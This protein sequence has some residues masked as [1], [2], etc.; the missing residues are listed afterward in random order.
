VVD[1]ARLQIPLCGLRDGDSFAFQILSQAVVQFG[2]TAQLE[3]GHRL[4]VLLD[5]RRVA[6]VAR[7]VSGRHV[8]GELRSRLLISA[9]K[10]FHISYLA[11]HARRR[12]PYQRGALRQVI[13]RS[14]PRDWSLERGSEVI[15]G[16]RS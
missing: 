2:E 12:G 16:V 4:L 13:G 1:E 14:E 7:G 6:D 15:E 11:V 9:A 3:V 10:Q 8:G 5:L